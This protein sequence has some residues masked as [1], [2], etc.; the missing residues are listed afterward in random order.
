MISRE[1]RILCKG[2]K[3]TGMTITDI[4]VKSE[5]NRSNMIKAI[6]EDK[7]ELIEEIWKSITKNKVRGLKFKWDGT[8]EDKKDHSEETGEKQYYLRVCLNCG[9][10]A[11][12]HYLGICPKSP[13]G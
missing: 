9:K 11:G 3:I 8:W 2:T 6:Q 13:E 4:P 12:L 10:R 5:F 1:I 7:P